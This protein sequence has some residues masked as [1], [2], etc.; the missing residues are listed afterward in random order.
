MSS[1]TLPFFLVLF[2]FLYAC[3]NTTQSDEANTLGSDSTMQEEN[4]APLTTP[5]NSTNAYAT[6]T[7]VSPPL[8]TVNVPTHRF[9]IDVSQGKTIEIKETGSSI[10]IP[11]N[12]FVDANG[13]P[14]KGEVEIQFKEYHDVADILTSGIP[15]RMTAPDGSTGYMQSAGMFDIKG[16]SQGK[17]IFVAEGK[18]LD[19][20]VA[21]DYNDVTYDFW[22]FEKDQQQWINRGPTKAKNNPV[23]KRA[24]K[25]IA[26]APKVEKPILPYKFDKNKPVLEFDINYDNFPELKEMNGIVWQYAGDDDLR[27]PVKNKWIFQENWDKAEIEAFPY[28]NLYKLILKSN[29][30]EFITTVSPSQSGEDFEKSMAEYSRKQNEYEANKLSIDDM[31]KLA[32]EKGNFIRSAKIEGF[33]IYNCDFMMR[34]DDNI[35]VD[36]EFDFGAMIPGINKLA[37]VYMI[38]DNRNI[39]SYSP[40]GT[41]RINPEAKTRMVAILPHQKYAT[42][43]ES[44]FDAMLDDIKAADGGQFKFKMSFKDKVIASLEQLKDTINLLV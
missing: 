6:D 10:V 2:T 5:Q 3:Q 25:R 30:K 8:G 17:A 11:A 14:I 44:E 15:M 28:G 32:E 41:I 22:K 18:T 31:K 37:T 1:R 40:L 36:A 26:K 12:A 9:K 16:T 19:V 23:K 35:L 29:S 43:S 42:I 33:G 21:S 34:D 7:N 24:L 13:H 38:M 20:N 27:D 39:V 4:S